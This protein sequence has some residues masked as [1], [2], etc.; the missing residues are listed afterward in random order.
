VLHDETYDA[1]TKQKALIIALLDETW[2]RIGSL[3]K[4]S[5]DW[6]ISLRASNVST[7]D[8]KIFFEYSWKSWKL[9]HVEINNKELIDFMNELVY[10]KEWGLLRW[11]QEHTVFSKTIRDQM[12]SLWSSWSPKDLRMWS[13]TMKFYDAWVEG[14]SHKTAIKSVSDYLWNT[15]EI[16]KKYYVPVLLQ[17]AWKSWVLKDMYQEVKYTRSTAYLSCDEHRVRKILKRLAM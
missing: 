13:G 12:N 8:N 14:V 1:I 9:Q 4:E 3:G 15:P 17:E 16:S 10:W 5:N 7:K 6:I 2:K 11:D